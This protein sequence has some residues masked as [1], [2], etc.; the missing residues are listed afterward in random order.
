MWFLAR[1]K[2]DDTVILDEPDV[3]MHADLQRRLIRLVKSR[4]PQ[5]IVATHSIE[6]M[7]EVEPEE[8]LVVDQGRREAKFADS[9]PAVQRIIDQIGGVHNLNLARLSATRRCLLLEGKDIEILKQF[10]NTLVPDAD[11]LLDTIPNMPIGG[12]GG[13]NYAVGSR[14]LLRNAL[15]E[16]IRTYCLLDS[17]YHT[18]EAIAGR[19]EEAARVGVCLHIWQRK[20]IENYLLVPSAILR[21][22]RSKLQKEIDGIT[23]DRVRSR[24]EKIAEAQKDAAFDAIS[25][26]ALAENRAKG[27]KFANEIARKRIDT[28]WS[29]L[30]GKLSVVSGKLLLSKLSEWGQNRFG[31]SLSA[32]RLAREIRTSEFEP[33]MRNVILAIERGCEFAEVFTADERSA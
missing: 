9:L 21:V 1:S 6:I 29:S 10:Q 18:A 19:Y 11:E 32:R 17:D 7:A 13:W 20:E 16:E 4:N 28:A 23:E 22:I 12:W 14:M 30:K 8:I 31:V 2:S 33:E 3:Y 25:Q 26:E 15:G 27:I 24:L 5:L